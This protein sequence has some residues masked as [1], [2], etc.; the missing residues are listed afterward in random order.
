MEDGPEGEYLT[1]RLTNETIS[2]IRDKKD[3]PFLAYLSFHTVHTPLQ[4]KPEAVQKYAEKI[5]RMG[6]DTLTEKDNSE[7]AYQNNP[8]YAAMVHHMDENVG[9]LMDAVEEMGLDENTV[10]IFTSDNGGKGSVTS[11]LP[12]KG[13]KH[14]LDEG[15]IRVATIIRW[16]GKIQAGSVC[17][18]PLI[19]NDFYPTMLELANAPLIPEQHMDGVSIK[20]VLLGN[21]TETG[22][23]AIYWHYPHSRMEGAI[24]KGDYKLLYYYNT[25]EVHLYNLMDDI[26]E[27]NDLSLE[28]PEKTEEMLGMLKT[29]LNEVGARFPADLVNQIQT[30]GYGKPVCMPSGRA[31]SFLA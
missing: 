29:W 18:E 27:L 23:E 16:T 21:K 6:L 1:D 26:G 13:M 11:N 24:R 31:E 22:R 28:E 7:K 10:V 19:S 25:G 3:K 2:F 20:D 9:R 14:N 5:S 8:N 4:A 15:G 17:S 30:G 12:L